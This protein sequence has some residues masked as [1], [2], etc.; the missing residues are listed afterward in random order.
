MTDGYG[1]IVQARIMRIEKPTVFYA[2][3][4]DKPENLCKHL[5]RD[6]AKKA[7][8]KLAKEAEIED[9]PR[10]DSDTQGESGHPEIASTIFAKIDDAAIFVADMTFTGDAATAD[11]RHKRVANANVLLELGYAS[12][13]M[14]W[15]RI[16]LVMNVASGPPEE[17]L[18]DILHRRH[19]ITYDAGDRT[20]ECFAAGT[21]VWTESGAQAIETI[22]IGDRVLIPR[23]TSRVV[24][25]LARK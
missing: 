1:A 12:A 2:W 4:S 20:R 18:F 22:K 16:V 3:Q 15:E 14:G 17:Q 6:A 11:N 9:S 13:R 25:G 10:L 8:K 7:I 21:P 5:I 23:G 24:P 19:P